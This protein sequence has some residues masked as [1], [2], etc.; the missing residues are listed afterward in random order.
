MM[1]ERIREVRDWIN[2][3][4][5]FLTVLIVP[6]GLLILKDQRLE[7][8]DQVRHEYI[9]RD[10]YTADREV[11]KAD[12]ARLATDVTDINVKLDHIQIN[13]ARLMDAAKLK[14]TGP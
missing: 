11:A 5:T 8:M 10:I 14:E 7:I 12:N 2:L 9:P 1:N 13:I 4:L 6:I 3:V